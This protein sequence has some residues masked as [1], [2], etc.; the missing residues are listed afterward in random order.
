MEVDL[1]ITLKIIGKAVRLMFEDNVSLGKENIIAQ[2]QAM[3]LTVANAEELIYY[4]L[5]I[6]LL[7][8]QGH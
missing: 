4:Q 3:S 8:E 7:S 5:A 6:Q 1:S 2:I